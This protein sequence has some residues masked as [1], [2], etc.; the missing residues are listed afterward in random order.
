RIYSAAED[1]SGT[2]ACVV[3][4]VQD[5]TLRLLLQRAGMPRCRHHSASCDHDCRPMVTGV[6]IL[7]CG[8]RPSTEALDGKAGQDAGMEH[9]GCRKPTSKPHGG[10]V[11]SLQFG[12]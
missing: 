7:G 2:P 5:A 11:V 12:G 8:G 3:H 4:P 9:G 10:T 6:L 1:M